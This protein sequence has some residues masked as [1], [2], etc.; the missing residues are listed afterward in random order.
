VQHIIAYME[1]SLA[2]LEQVAGLAP[3]KAKQAPKPRG[4]V[5]R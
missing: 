3:A 1:D 4:K 5:I 2:E